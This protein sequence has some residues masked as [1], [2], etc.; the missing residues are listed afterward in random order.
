MRQ[1][2]RLVLFAK[3]LGILFLGFLL[4]VAFGGSLAFI[5]SNLA[6]FA[7]Y[8]GL[9]LTAVVF[10]LFR[11]KNRPWK[12][13]YEATGWILS[14]AERKSHPT[15]AKY[16]RIIQRALLGLPSAT[17]AFVLFFFPLASHLIH[18][19]WRYS[20][21]YRVPI[22][23][24]VT[25]LFPTGGDVVGLLS[26]SGPGRFGVTPFWGR[27]QLF[28]LMTFAGWTADVFVPDQ[29]RPPEGAVQP[30]SRHFNVGSTGVNCWQYLPPLGK[31]FRGA[32]GAKL[33]GDWMVACETPFDVREHFYASFHGSEEDLPTFYKIVAGVTPVK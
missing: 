13:E 17:A 14:Q 11:R 31:R 22:P 33:S 6:G 12:I 15:R 1:S 27:E 8:F 19:H 23:W 5:G 3:E 18:P 9:L 2:K 4:S 26:S 21:A 25:V 16:K 28:S 7:F 10:F 32:L 20:S 29:A 24:I 30:Y